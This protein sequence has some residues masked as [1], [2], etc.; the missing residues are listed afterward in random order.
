M[1]DEPKC[2]NSSDGTHRISWH[3]HTNSD[4]STKQ[5]ASCDAC[6]SEW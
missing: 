3:E 2:P 6:G 4:G 1:S 5:V